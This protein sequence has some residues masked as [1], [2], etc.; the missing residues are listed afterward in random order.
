VSQEERGVQV[1]A[2]NGQTASIG[3]REL[4][5]PV[6][7]VAA[8]ESIAGLRWLRVQ[9]STVPR[10]AGPLPILGRWCMRPAENPPMAEAS[11]PL[12]FAG[13]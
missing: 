8:G 3:V 7:G 11:P 2:K 1:L 12:I 13:A 10:K 4:Q 5:V 6:G 9:P